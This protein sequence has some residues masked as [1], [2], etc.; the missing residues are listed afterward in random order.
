MTQLDF[1]RILNSMAIL[2]VVIPTQGVDIRAEVRAYQLAMVLE[3]LRQTE[4]NVSKSASLL[5]LNR[6]TLSEMMKKFK[7]VRPD[8]FSAPRKN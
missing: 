2:E 7:L 4:W 6:T 8:E 3:A 5:G 1:A